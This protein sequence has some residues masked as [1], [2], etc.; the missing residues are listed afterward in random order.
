MY[1]INQK[2]YFFGGDKATSHQ[3]EWVDMTNVTLSATSNVA[4]LFS[5]I[6]YWMGSAVV[7][8]NYVYLRN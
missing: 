7:D 8:N 4:H 6:R 1:L 3:I 5:T 2:L